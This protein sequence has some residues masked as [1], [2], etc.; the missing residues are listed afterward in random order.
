MDKTAVVWDGT[1]PRWTL[2]GHDGG[3]T[4]VACSPA[5][6]VLASASEDGTIKLWDLESGSLIATLWRVAPGASTGLGAGANDWLTWTPDQYYD[7]SASAE[8]YVQF[9]DADGKLHPATDYAEAM[10]KPDRLR[11]ALARS[12]SGKR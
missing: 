6:R 3:V 2:E 7:C 8:R 1:T 12:V 9:R 5:G 4:A 10:R 11:A